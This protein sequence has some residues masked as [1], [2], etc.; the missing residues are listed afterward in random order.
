MKCAP[1]V[2][3]PLHVQHGYYLEDDPRA[4]LLRRNVGAHEKLHEALHDPR[5]VCLA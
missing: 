2:D 5:G 4:G 1:A 3:D